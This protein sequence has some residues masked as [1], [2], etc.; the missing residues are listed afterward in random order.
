MNRSRPIISLIWA[1]AENRVIGKDN[2]LPWHLPADLRHFKSLTLGKPILMGRK[3]WESLPGLLPDRQH[4]VLSRD[5]AYRA[6]G[7]SLVHSVAE[8]LDAAG[9]AP[10]LMVVGGA[11]LYEAMLPLADRLYVT[12]VHAEAEGDT[13][14]PPFTL[15]EWEEVVREDHPQD[16]RNPYPYSFLELRRKRG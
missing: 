7:C 14:F 15:S 6:D 3:T 11:A 5:M 10:E 16:D 8:A 1:M 2:R 13:F 12:L 9:E 4:I